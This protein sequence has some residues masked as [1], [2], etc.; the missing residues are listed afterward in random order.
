[1]LLRDPH[2]NTLN[3]SESLKYL[4]SKKKLFDSERCDDFWHYWGRL[5][6]QNKLIAGCSSFLFH[7][8]PVP[9][10][11]IAI[12]EGKSCSL[13]Q[14]KLKRK[15]Y[16]MHGSLHPRDKIMSILYCIFKTAF[17]K[18]HIWSLTSVRYENTRNIDLRESIKF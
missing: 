17:D 1:M 9:S 13:G 10:I 3:F 4:F 11:P 16:S 18:T 5:C 8:S 15:F 12:T 14:L 2:M 6:S 7:E